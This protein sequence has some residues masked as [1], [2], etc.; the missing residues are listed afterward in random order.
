MMIESVVSLV[1]L[2]AVVA[3]AINTL[4]T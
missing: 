2:I 1:T 3:R 4:G